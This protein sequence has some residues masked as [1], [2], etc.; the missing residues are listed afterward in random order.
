V[1]AAA[2]RLASRH[3]HFYPRPVVSTEVALVPARVRA[4][5]EAAVRH[6][7][8][9]LLA[10]A[11]RLCGNTA[12][13][14]DLVQDTYERALKAWERLPSDAN[15]RGWLVTI[16]NRLFIDRCRR[17]KRSPLVDREAPEPAAP[18]REVDAAP[19][20]SAVTSEQLAS[21]VARL[22]EEF[23]RVYELHAVGRSY[24]EIGDEL[25]VP[26]ATVGTRLLRARRRLRE[27]LV[28][29]LGAR[30]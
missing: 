13:A 1:A 25:G 9:V 12:D 20:W 26:A 21:A 28:A 11:G 10:I 5:F 27:L 15:H 14:R 17:A 4:G 8:P 30:S 24:K 29:D 16:M 18:E 19:A 6:H 7:E 23:R 3:A 22:G 2:L